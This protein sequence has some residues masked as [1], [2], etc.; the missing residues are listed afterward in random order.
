MNTTATLPKTIAGLTESQIHAYFNEA[1]T[2]AGYSI[3]YSQVTSS[4]NTW[5]HPVEGTPDG[6]IC[7]TGKT[8]AEAISVHESKRPASGLALAAEKRKQAEA[9]IAEAEAITAKSARL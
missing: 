4:F 2:L 1:S 7:E 3:G 8:L 6:Y 5:Q 9:L